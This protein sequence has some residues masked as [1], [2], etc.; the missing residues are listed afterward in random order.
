MKLKHLIPGDTIGIVAPASPSDTNFINKKIATFNSLG[1]NIKKG[2]YIY[3]KHGYLCGT[4]KERAD[5]LI[6]MFI[7]P[8]VDA[9]VCFRGGYGSIRL[10]DNLD[11]NLIKSHPKPFCGYSDITILLNYLNRQCKFPT[12]HGPMINSNFNDSI[13]KNY[14]INVLTNSNKH[15]SYDLKN[16]ENINILNNTDFEGKLVGGNLS[17]ICSAIGTPYDINFKN[18]IVF[19]EEVN[20]NPYVID[21]LL[22]QMIYANKFKYCN[23]IILGHFTDCSLSDYS[24]SFTLEDIIIQKL[25]PLNI[26]IIKNFPA[27]HSY[28]NITLPIGCRL[29]YDSR[30]LLLTMS[31]NIFI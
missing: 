26:P 10:L 17:M 22:S 12:F 5:D 4:D 27:G 2:N 6:N 14:F 18:S 30:T 15:F 7:D 29:N 25:M 19:L 13:T 20:E 21:R 16:M 9:I 24:K 28:P 8:S 31:E 1:F 23:G 11:L 3:K